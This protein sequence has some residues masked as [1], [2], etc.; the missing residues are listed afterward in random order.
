[1]INGVFQDA[2][3]VWLAARL[4]MYPWALHYPVKLI[5]TTATKSLLL[6]LIGQHQYSVPLWK[7]NT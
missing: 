2:A 4:L 1:M 7:I 6:L 5:K 3:E